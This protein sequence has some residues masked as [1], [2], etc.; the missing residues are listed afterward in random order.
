MI[1]AKAITSALYS[2][3]RTKG[4]SAT[5]VLTLGVTL[6]ALVAMFNLNYQLLAVPLPYPDAER[7][8]T[9]KGNIYRDNQLT[10][11]KNS[12]Y[13]ALVETYKNNTSF[14]EKAL[15]YFWED[16][17]RSLPDSPRVNVTYVTPEYLQLADAPLALGRHFTPEEG[18]D[19]YVPV[20]LLSYQSWKQQFNLDPNVLERTIRFGEVDF[21]IIG[22]TAKDFIEPEVYAQGRQTQVWL[23]WDYN[24]TSERNRNSWRGFLPFRFLV[25]KLKTTAVPAT[26]EHELT[27]SLNARYQEALAGRT[28]GVELAVTYTLSPYEREILGDNASRTLLMLAGTLVLL[29]IA[30]ANITNL[31][32]SRAANRQRTM[33]IQ[34]ALGAQRKHIFADLLVEIC[35]LMLAAALL[36]ILFAAAGIELIKQLATDQIPRVQEL[37]LNWQT[38][39]FAVV[40]ALLLAVFFAALV[41][42]QI[43]YRLLNRML[44]SSGK[45]AGIQISARTRQLLIASQIAL[46]GILIA[47]SLQVFLQSNRYINQPL[48]FS[49]R[50]IQVM[51]LNIGN[52]RNTP[53]EQRHSDLRA[54]REKLLSHPK[55]LNASL[56][57]NTPIGFSRPLWQTSLTTDASRD[58]FV[59]A[60]TAVIDENYLP[61]LE[62]PLLAGRHLSAAEFNDGSRVMLVNQTLARQLRVDGQVVGKQFYWRD[63]DPY[64]VI[65]VVQDASL[66]GR[67]EVPRLFVRHIDVDY[68]QITLKFEPGQPLAPTEL[69]SLFAEVS[70]QY[71]VSEIFTLEEARDFLLANDR[72]SAWLTSGLTLLALALAA[73]GIYG[74]LSYSI[75]LRRFEL[76]IRMAIGARPATIFTQV[77]RENLVPVAAGLAA[78]L[79]A[80]A[81][82]WLWIEQSSYTLQVSFSGWLLP[83]LLILLLVSATSLLAVWRIISRPAI[84]ALRSS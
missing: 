77:L 35:L 45:G 25:G 44:Q 51:T 83:A 67:D 75:R 41:S 73:I 46:T 49:T 57:L 72:L 27:T 8:Y 68:P 55:V 43:D 52:L 66:P 71:K 70:G 17:V 34:V 9:V 7:L 29:L 10:S 78:A 80:L 21:R 39:L 26:A 65:G 40:A 30:A 62:F 16:V 2:L 12:Q 64:R 11:E 36:S 81:G 47:A 53:A 59:A 84:G 56:G 19:Q 61:I 60:K 31:I 33:A 24:D 37:S 74:V 20:A 18:L 32:L 3:G 13:P 5:I 1:D 38:C 23:P 6:G 4:Y 79:V 76:G 48:G 14:A 82:L 58:F 42:R 54:I 63:P 15:V 50:D 28:S 69:N 22:V